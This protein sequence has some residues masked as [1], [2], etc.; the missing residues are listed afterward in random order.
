[1]SLAVARMQKEVSAVRAENDQLKIQGME[2]RRKI[3]VLL[4]MTEPV[5]NRVAEPGSIR[6]YNSAVATARRNTGSLSTSR[7]LPVTRKADILR[8]NQGAH[9]ACHPHDPDAEFAFMMRRPEADSYLGLSS[10]AA[11]IGPG[12][13]GTM[14][15]VDRSMFTNEKVDSLLLA[16]AS[17]S[18]QLAEQV[19]VNDDN[20]AA[21]SEASLE[22]AESSRQIE[23]KAMKTVHALQDKLKAVEK[24]LL[25]MTHNYLTLRHHVSLES[26]AHVE[27]VERLAREKHEAWQSAEAM[28]GKYKTDSE[29]AVAAAEARAAEYSEHYRSQAA[30]RDED[31]M[32][33]RDQFSFTQRIV[34]DR[35]DSLRGWALQ[36]KR[37]YRALEQRRL[38]DL[39]G[40]G[41]DMAGLRGQISRMEAT[42]LQ[43]KQEG[44]A[45]GEAEEE[46]YSG[47]GGG[48]GVGGGRSLRRSRSRG[49]GSASGSRSGSASNSK[50]MSGSKHKQQQQQQQ[51]Q[52]RPASRSG[53]LRVSASKS[54]DAVSASAAAPS[55]F[56]SSSSGH[57]KQGVVVSTAAPSAQSQLFGHHQGMPPAAGVGKLWGPAVDETTAAAFAANGLPSGE[58]EALDVYSRDARERQ[59]R[60]ETVAEMQDLKA[61]LDALQGEFTA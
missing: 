7:R 4:T 30:D 25:D 42:V 46:S 20:T 50:G 26:R 44:E 21:F 48:G 17:L 22:L 61:Q 58:A 23:G 32:I 41:V 59:R 40:M 31:M 11:G 24:R 34:T 13:A 47:G 37:R 10:S 15:G 6:L 51:Q 54:I 5:A 55:G 60:A 16:H 19:R 28:S 57:R 1:M 9:L 29:R 35:M 33:M 52:Q 2:D 8:Q 3:Q 53:V 45:E 12:S 14:S 36:L 39:E 43:G 18:N 38:W 56:S 27:A 49:T